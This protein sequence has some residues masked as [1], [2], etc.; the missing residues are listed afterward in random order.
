MLVDYAWPQLQCKRLYFQHD[1]ATPH[2]VV[3]KGEWLDEKFPGRWIVRHGPFDWPAHSPDL[4]SCDFFLWG[5]LKD[6]VF[7]ES[8]T[9]IMQLQNRIQDLCAGITKVMCRKVCH[10]VA[11]RLRGCL[12]KDGQFLSS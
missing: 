5:Y 2:Y 12:E 9:S 1:G 8:C 7:K 3:I 4:T 6:I 10:S 11:Q